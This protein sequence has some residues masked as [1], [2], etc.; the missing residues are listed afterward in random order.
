MEFQ[1]HP[2]LTPQ[3]EKLCTHRGAFH[4]G[5]TIVGEQ[6]G[7]FG[8][9]SPTA[10]HS[11]AATAGTLPFT[12]HGAHFAHALNEYLRSLGSKAMPRHL[13]TRAPTCWPHHSHGS[14]FPLGRENLGLQH[15][16][17]GAMGLCGLHLPVSGG[18]PPAPIEPDCPQP[19]PQTI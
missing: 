10:N 17:T 7:L 5:G 13:P 12:G 15:T 19:G 16:K 3:G 2:R 4:W 6:C 9:R 11:T 8:G 14:V 1:P 18:Q